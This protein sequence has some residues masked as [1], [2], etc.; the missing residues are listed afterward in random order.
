MFS[1]TRQLLLSFVFAAFATTTIVSASTLD[2]VVDVVQLKGVN[3]ET[4]W[5][6]H[7]S[8][9]DTSL[10]YKLTSTGY[11]AVAELHLIIVTSYGDSL[12]DAWSVS[13]ESS[14][15]NPQHAGYLTGIRRLSLRPG[16]Y[17]VNI[18]VYDQQD[19][20][21][22]MK[23]SFQTNVRNF[24]RTVS[25]S[26]L[27]FTRT[28]DAQD[29]SYK[30]GDLII[31][32]NPRHEC[33]GDDPSLEFYFEVYDVKKYGVDTVLLEF[34]I[35]DYVNES[36]TQ[37]YVSWGVDKDMVGRRFALPVPTFASGVYKLV[38]VLRSRRDSVVLFTA[39]DRFY[40]LNP[41]RLPEG[42]ELVSDEQRFVISE[43]YAMSPER[44][45]LQMQLAAII[46]TP[47]ELVSMEKLTDTRSK[48]RFLYRFWGTRD[49][50]PTTEINEALLDYRLRF[51]RANAQ[52]RNA[53]YVEGWKTDRGR[54]LLKYGTPTQIDRFVQ[55]LDTR[56][57]E[58]W[59]Y[60]SVQGGA[61]FHFVDWQNTQNHQLV[62]STAM[63]EIRND[64]WYEQFA[65]AYSPDPFN[66]D[67]LK[68]NQR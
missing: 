18:A 42:R 38:T 28:G 63:G 14:E 22:Y 13:A 2:V 55:T 3:D 17:S 23:S 10:S 54:I 20:S 49:P 58:T 57:Y 56:P 19:T 37:S 11:K 45:D 35:L 46:A 31:L 33:I 15:R 53:Q 52:Y 51:E 27:V 61:Y 64:N 1:A 36:V 65:K 41:T 34:R 9:P 50:D 39:E 6:L 62:H 32:P 24:G 47:L 29:T 16:Q 26:D 21:R 60:Q 43:W 66:P 4:R 7:Y 8:I 40:V 68:P 59:Y 5:E 67:R 48:Q 12:F 44:T 30:R 25:M